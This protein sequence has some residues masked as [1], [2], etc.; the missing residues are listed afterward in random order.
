MKFN[1]QPTQCLRT[2]L[3]KFNLKEQKKTRINFD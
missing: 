2:R 3:K 1:S